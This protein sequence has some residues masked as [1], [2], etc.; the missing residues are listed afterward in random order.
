[1]PDVKSKEFLFLPVGSYIRKVTSAG[2]LT[3]PKKIRKALGLEGAEYF[4]VAI[5]GRAAVIRRLRE[6]DAMLP[7]IRSKIKK[8]GVTRARVRELV[9]DAARKAWKKRYREAVR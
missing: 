3:L 1:M 7:A 9:D 4:E 2:Q 6:D 5:L 8:S